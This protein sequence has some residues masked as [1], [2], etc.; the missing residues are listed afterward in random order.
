[1]ATLADAI[2]DTQKKVTEIQASLAA[3]GTGAPT[4]LT[5]VLSAVAAVQADT[6]AIKSELTPTPA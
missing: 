3:G 5:P 4:D 6:T 1:M 2:L